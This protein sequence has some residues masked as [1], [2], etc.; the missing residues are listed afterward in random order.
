M[1]KTFDEEYK[2]Y[3]QELYKR[4]VNEHWIEKSY[5]YVGY[6]LDYIKRT[7]TIPSKNKKDWDNFLDISAKEKFALY[8]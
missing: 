7:R 5:Q 3:C 6:V 1:F 4:H 8:D 2:N